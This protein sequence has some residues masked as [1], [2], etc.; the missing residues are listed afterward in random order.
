MKI[1][2]LNWKIGAEAGEGVMVT[3]LIFAKTCANMGLKIFGYPEYPSRIRGGHNCYQ[4]RVRNNK[5]TTVESK[6]DILIALN[7]ETFELHQG[8]LHPESI[9]VIDE[10]EKTDTFNYSRFFKV[11]MEQ[12]AIDAG[13][14]ITKN[15]VS[16]GVTFAMLNLPVDFI[17]K[18]MQSVF[19]DKGEKIL[20]MNTKAVLAGYNYT[21]E[22]FKYNFPFKL[23]PKGESPRYVVTGNEA[24]AIG[25][26]KA[27]L[28]LY[29]AYPMTPASSILH[30]LAPLARDYR[31]LVKH[32]EDEIAA[33]LTAIGANYAGIRAMAAT[34]GGGFSLM[35]EALGMAAITETPLVIAECQRPGPSTGMPTWT[36][37]GDL[38]FVMHASQ[39]DFVR[40]VLSPGDVGEAYHLTQLAFNLAEKYQ[41]PVIILSDKLLSESHDTIQNF[42]SLDIPV[43]R[44]KRLT[45]VPEDYKRYD[46]S[47]ADGIS[48]RAF[49]P[50]P[51]GMHLANSDEHD[52][53]GL[54][55]EES[56]MRNE[57]QNKRFKRLEMIKNDTPPPVFYGKKDADISFVSFGSTKN[58]ILRAMELLETEGISCNY[59]HC[60]C[61]MPLDVQAFKNFIKNS[62]KLIC[63]EN[64]YTGQFASVLQENLCMEINE[65]LLKSDGRPFFPDE[66]VSFV[67]QKLGV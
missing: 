2:D 49:P 16:L 30:F 47:I 54:V 48:Y 64:N 12:L 3:G 67:K 43:E 51:N 36:E 28:K 41:I 39:G 24:I 13:G 15:N 9:V 66:I 14:K 17:L 6:I 32:T 29:A 53:Y 27:G 40:I 42:Q 1:N 44:G 62:K 10:K 34:S 4:V 65:R 21:K 50:S 7:T 31:I 56:E 38:R 20:E 63:I 23:E 45:D 55:S 33:I 57:M 46:L 22:H 11:P 61:P 58:A 37:Q 35:V 60:L 19:K 52:E 59:L 26:V 5:T 18:T 8:E 25:A